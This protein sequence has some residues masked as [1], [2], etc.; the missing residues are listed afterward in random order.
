M[1]DVMLNA[2]IILG[3]TKFSMFHALAR[4]VAAEKGTHF[5]NMIDCQLYVLKSGLLSDFYKS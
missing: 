5:V 2:D 4:C 1:C 3:Y